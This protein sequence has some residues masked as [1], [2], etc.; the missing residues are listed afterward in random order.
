MQGK[1]KCYVIKKVFA[2]T[3]LV[4]EKQEGKNKL[5]HSGEKSNSV[6]LLHITHD[7]G[8]Q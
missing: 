5:E 4:E 6:C 2:G 7:K 8:I 1:E 3:F